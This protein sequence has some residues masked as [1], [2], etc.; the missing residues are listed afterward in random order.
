MRSIYSD[1]TASQG[2]AGLLTSF[3][4]SYGSR[5]TARPLQD[6]GNNMQKL[7]VFVTEVLQLQEVGKQGRSQTP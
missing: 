3:H 1:L 4:T 7:P 6:I 5:R 2:V